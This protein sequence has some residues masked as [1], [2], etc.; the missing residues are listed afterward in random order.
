MLGDLFLVLESC[1]VYIKR[2]VVGARALGKRKCPSNT[3][4]PKATQQDL[5]NHILLY[6]T[7][8]I[9]YVPHS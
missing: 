8:G 2:G 7:N 1:V 3:R 9:D 5:S 6:K 4:E